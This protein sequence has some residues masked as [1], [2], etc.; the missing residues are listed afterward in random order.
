LISAPDTA[1]ANANLDDG[2]MWPTYSRLKELTSAYDKKIA[3]LVK[4]ATS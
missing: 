3:A 2:N 4:K 1:G